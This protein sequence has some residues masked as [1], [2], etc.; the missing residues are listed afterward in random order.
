MFPY[1]Q[2]GLHSGT[3]PWHSLQQ[4]RV[5]TTFYLLTRD[6]RYMVRDTVQETCW[7]R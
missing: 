4:E 3:L 2:N 5:E 1:E 7:T 6:L